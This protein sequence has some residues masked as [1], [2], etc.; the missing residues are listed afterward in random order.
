MVVLALVAPVL[1]AVGL[2][3]M[4]VAFIAVLRRMRRRSRERAA[5][6]STPPA[7]LA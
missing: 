1:V 2:V 3:L 7:F 4:L 6:E 5:A